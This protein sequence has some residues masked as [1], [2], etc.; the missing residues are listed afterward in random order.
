VTVR[1]DCRVDI[2]ATALAE[3][4]QWLPIDVTRPEHTTVADL[5]GENMSGPLR[6]SQGTVRDYLI[7]LCWHDRDGTRISSGGRVVKNVAGYDLAKMHIGARGAFGEIV[8]ATLKVRP[9]PAREVA[10]TFECGSGRE[11]AVEA[12]AVRDLVEP[13]WCVVVCAEGRARVVVG[14]MGSE[15]VVEAHADAVTG[16]WRGVREDDGA[17]VRADLAARLAESVGRGG[18]ASMLAGD[19]GDHLDATSSRHAASM[20]LADVL[21]GVVTTFPPPGRSASV[22]S[23]E[24]AASRGSVVRRLRE[25]LDASFS[26]HHRR[27]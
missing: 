22:D 18:A 26:I 6:A 23:S 8:E 12:L 25:A 10:V 7:G 16:R 24:R 5:V 15:R 4:G 3:H 2:L 11:A 27:D 9:R 21:S 17:R 1:G 14:M 13:A 20:V 19:V